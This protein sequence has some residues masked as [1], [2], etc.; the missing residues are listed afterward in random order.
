VGADDDGLAGF[1]EAPAIVV[2]ASHDHA[3]AHEDP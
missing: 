3:Q 2:L 1:T